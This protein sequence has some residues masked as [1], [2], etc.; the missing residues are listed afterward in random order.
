MNFETELKDFEFLELL[1][2]GSFGKV[3]FFFFLIKIYLILL[4]L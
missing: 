1:G 3:Y 4:F 2:S